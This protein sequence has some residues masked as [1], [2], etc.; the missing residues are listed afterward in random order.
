MAEIAKA[1]RIAAQAVEPRE[2][3][4]ATQRKHA[5]ARS[6]WKP[7]DLP[8]WL[9]EETYRT[10][11]QP[12]LKNIANPV[13]MSVL[14]VSVTYAVAIRAGRRQPHPRLWLKLAQ[15]VGAPQTP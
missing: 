8:A 15:L 2:R 7:T 4:A 11:I 9:N 1:G 5:L 13:I 3:M 6:A 12:L 10:K 14:G